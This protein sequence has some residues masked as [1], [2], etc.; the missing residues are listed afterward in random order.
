MSYA[1]DKFLDLSKD[2]AYNFFRD[3]K[4]LTILRRFTNIFAVIFG[5]IAIVSIFEYGIIHIITLG[6]CIFFVSAVVFRI[7][8]KTI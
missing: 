6:Y 4:N 3:E 2:D 1:F 5:I 8:I 7:Y